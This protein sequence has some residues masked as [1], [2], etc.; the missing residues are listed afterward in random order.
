M[1]VCVLS[2]PQNYHVYAELL[3]EIVI[4]FMHATT[5]KSKKSIMTDNPE[6]VT[7]IRRVQRSLSP[8]YG[9]CRFRMKLFSVV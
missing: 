1:Y 4:T 5:S 6:A 9:L 3:Q 7:R 8:S 2:T